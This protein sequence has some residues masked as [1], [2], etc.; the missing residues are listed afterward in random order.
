MLEELKREVYEA[1]L[2][3]PRFGLV[4][5]TWGNVS[6]ISRSQGLVVIK[7][8]GL[9]Y[10]LI[11]PENMVVVDLDGKVVEGDLK[12]SSDT[13]THIELY[14][15]FP[16]IGGVAHTHSRHATIFAQ[17]RS[18]IPPYGT[19]HADYFHGPIPCARALTDEEIEGDYERNTGRVIAER[20]PDYEGIPA[21]L[22]ANH[23]P[24]T[25][26]ENAQAAAYHAVVLEEIAFMAL[27][28]QGADPVSQALLD[29]HYF[30]KHG[31]HAYYGQS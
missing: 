25:W 17:N 4:L 1:N 13:P 15:S 7:P 29:K 8:S 10:E 28:N 27:R 12:P 3:L 11:R 31:P 16:K 21:V 9:E 30:R 18:P 19:T 6:G 26:G 14:R 24:F 22:V 2:I 20:H 23:G 5:F